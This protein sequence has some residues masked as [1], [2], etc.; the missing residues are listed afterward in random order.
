MRRSSIIGHAIEV[1]DLIRSSRQPADLIVKEFFRKRHYLGAK[2]RR[3]ISSMV[4]GVLRRFFLLEAWAREV[5]DRVNGPRG[6]V[7]S[8]ALVVID[9]AKSRR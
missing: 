9:A 2:D 7:P 1:L 5:F 4:Y 3:S 6:T 8:I